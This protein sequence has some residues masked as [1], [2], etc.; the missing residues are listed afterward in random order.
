M[1]KGK[2]EQLMRMRQQIMQQ[3]MLK[4][5]QAQQ[6]QIQHSQQL[7]QAQAQAQAAPPPQFPGTSPQLT[8]AALQQAAMRK[9][10]G[11][12]S[13]MGLPNPGTFPNANPYQGNQQFANRNSVP[14][15][16]SPTTPA[17]AN[18]VNTNLA[19]GAG[20]SGT[21]GTQGTPGS[22]AQSAPLGKFSQQ[23][24]TQLQYEIFIMTLNDF[25]ARRGTP[26]THQP[27]I[28]NKK[29]NLLFLHLLS[30]KLGGPQQLTRAINNLQQQPLQQ[31]NPFTAMC[32]KLNLFDG[33][34]IQQDFNSR[35]RIEK[36]TASV[37]VQYILPYEQYSLTP[38][39]SRELQAKRL[40]FQKQILIKLQQQQQPQ[41][42][43]QQ[44]PPQ[45]QSQQPQPQIPQ[46]QLALKPP[47]RQVSQSHNMS[48]PAIQSPAINNVPTPGVQQSPV[49]LSAPTPQQR[50]TS[51]AS[52]S[53]HNSPAI[54]SPYTLQQN[55]SR[56]NSVVNTPQQQLKKENASVKPSPTIAE[57]EPSEPNVI[58]NYVPLRKLLDTH[59]GFD[60]KALSQLANEIEMTKPVYLFA[61]ELGSI[62][63]HGLIMALK[64][65]HGVD[66]G[67]IYSALNTLLVTTL[68]S[69][70]TFKITDVPELLD[71]LSLL[72]VKILEQIVNPTAR[73]PDVY[74][75]AVGL[76]SNSNIDDVFNKYVHGLQGED[77]AF[78]V[79]SLSAEVVEDDDDSDID[80]DDIFSPQ[81][82]TEVA[83]PTEETVASF[84]IPDYMT[85]LLEF[86]KENKHHFSK[87]QVKSA[88]DEQVMLV[89]ELITITMI[90][91]NVSF[92]D[93]SRALM[94]INPLFRDLLFK[95]VRSIAL[96][97]ERFVFARKRLCVLK[98]CLLM[99]NNISLV[100][101]LRSLEEAF[102]S[103]ALIMSFGPKLEG[104]EIPSAPLDSYT[105]LPY[106][107]DALTKLL[108]KEPRNK[109]LMQAVLTGSLAITSAPNYPNIAAIKID[110]DDET[111]TKKLAAAFFNGD[112]AAFENGALLTKAFQLFLSIVPFESNSF[113]FAKFS[114]L[115]APILTQ[116]LFGA[117]LVIDMVPCEEGLLHAALLS[118][119]LISNKQVILT[120]FART[121]ISLVTE[122]CKYP[123]NTNE[124]KLLSL[125][126]LKSLIVVNSLV[127]NA[128]LLLDLPSL[129]DKQQLHK[130][131]ELYR[132]SPEETFALD[133]FLTPAVDQDVSYE[134]V[135][136]VGLLKKLR[137]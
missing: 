130:L 9:Y 99:L 54:Q 123:R 78:V 92:S 117:K 55:I 1:E 127:A 126:I 120:S 2:Q 70:Y 131:S 16:A 65:Y 64:N 108:V 68:D 56:S 135:R 110:A 86:K 7:V 15:A 12:P 20:A 101:E 77:V 128:V 24:L 121:A 94:A 28:N 30:Q 119:W 59:N 111:N 89:D 87:I 40:Q 27:V 90:L 76:R 80:L 6:A 57:A 105:Y 100:M 125:V 129:V 3:Q 133:S 49:A 124:N 83:E 35:S 137:S 114:F 106:A 23:Q 136:L 91:R 69:N 98:D 44:Q 62:N 75:S 47:L 45:Q 48:P 26:L 88:V 50:K 73:H 52:Q 36:E 79:D 33:V 71:V 53:N 18:P 17:S 21:Q 113:D 43:Q 31:P 14:N 95:C 81:V 93:G 58:K 22:G 5:Q 10:A 112:T 118:S 132:V 102:L 38:N 46:Q 29:V 116:A 41:Q 85:T 51:Q 25:M 72:G 115:R 104:S 13:N 74:E 42:Q 39:G 60:I 103:F 61:P 34:N 11:S 4:Q 97:P 96:H 122:S 37:Y 32:Q 82:E 109:T 8:Q 63:I 107:I 84:H 66:D 67:E 134:I 19:N